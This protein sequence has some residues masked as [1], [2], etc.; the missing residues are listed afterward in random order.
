VR[1]AANVAGAVADLCAECTLPNIDCKR[2]AQESSVARWATVTA[3]VK[4]ALGVFAF[5]GTLLQ[6]VNAARQRSYFLARLL[7]GFVGLIREGAHGLGFVPSLFA[8]RTQLLELRSYAFADGACSLP[9]DVPPQPTGDGFR[10]LAVL[11]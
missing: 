6:Q 9:I 5:V 10:L 1:V 8:L 11:L 4:R 2:D 3:C 7:R